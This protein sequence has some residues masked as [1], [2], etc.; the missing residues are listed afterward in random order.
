MS[1]IPVDEGNDECLH[2]R[3]FDMG[4][5]CGPTHMKYGIPPCGRNII[6][7]Q[8]QFMKHLSKRRQ[9]ECRKE[10]EKL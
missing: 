1:C 10:L 5:G 8:E 6:L 7:A 2:C 4:N 9:K 3:F